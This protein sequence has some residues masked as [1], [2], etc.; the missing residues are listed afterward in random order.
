MESSLGSDKLGY[1]AGEISKKMLKAQPSFS[2]LLIVKCKRTEVSGRN[3]CYAKKE[4]ELEDLGN[5]QPIYIEKKRE[6]ALWREPP[7]CGWTAIYQAQAWGVGAGG[8]ATSSVPEVLAIILGS[9]SG[10]PSWWAWKTKHQSI[11]DP[12]ENAF[13]CI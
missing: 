2:L 6:T 8:R 13:H 1:L 3:N 11:K 7:G 9:G 10:L 5:S 12:Y 4:T